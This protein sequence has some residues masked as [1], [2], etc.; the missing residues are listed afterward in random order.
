VPDDS[1]LTEKDRIKRAEERLLPSQ[2]PL[3]PIAGP[4]NPVVQIE[5]NI[6]DADDQLSP[7]PPELL[8]CEPA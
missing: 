6:Y 2:P 8:D 3:A 5:E 7:H 4:S 1:A